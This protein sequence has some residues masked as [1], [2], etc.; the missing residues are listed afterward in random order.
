[1]NEKDD[2]QWLAALAG[3]P[4]KSADPVTNAQAQAVRDAMLARRE[5]LEAASEQL[6]SGEFQRLQSRLEREGFLAPHQ[7]SPNWIPGWLR[8]LLPM[9]DGHVAALPVW[10]LGVNAVL[11]VVVVVQL[12]V[13]G[14]LPQEQDVLRGEQ[15]TVL[16]VADPQARL[17]ELV[18]GLDS[19]KARYVVQRSP[20]GELTLLIQADDAALDFLISQRIEPVV[21]DG[22]FVIL[23]QPSETP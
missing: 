17:T 3:K 15:G 6:D 23:L 9:K 16:R 11:A 2:D 10:S 19:E 20:E 12:G 4:D 13:L 1:M 22:L 21:K 7:E 5:S 14:S 18:K 8:N